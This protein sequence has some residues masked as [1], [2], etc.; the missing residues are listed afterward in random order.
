MSP[1]VRRSSSRTDNSRGLPAADQTSTEG[2]SVSRDAKPVAASSRETVV[3]V[4]GESGRAAAGPGSGAEPLHGSRSEPLSSLDTNAITR[5]GRERS[6]HHSQWVESIREPSH[7]YRSARAGKLRDKRLRK[8]GRL[9]LDGASDGEVADKTKWYRDRERAQRERID[10]VHAC[11][12]NLLQ[13]TCQSCERTH[14]R[15]QGCRYGLLCV[16]CR[17]LIAAEKRSRFLQ[18][19]VHWLEELNRAGLIGER[20]GGKRYSEKMLTLTVPHL[21]TDTVMRRIERVFAVWT[22]FLRKLNKFFRERRIKRAHYYRVFEWTLGEAD[23]IGNP[24][25]H[26]WLLC[27]FLDRDRLTLMLRDALNA[28]GCCVDHPVLD[29]RAVKDGQGGAYELI[30]YLTKDITA[31]GEKVPPN[32]YAQVLEAVETRRLTQPS[33][34]FLAPVKTHA[35]ACECGSELP[36]IVRT[37]PIDAS[38]KGSETR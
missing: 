12:A 21:S 31:S 29:I 28:V 4:R 23:E 22:Q 10:R 26:V 18:A 3:P 36:R 15:A 6:V 1:H 33:A 7:P 13:I 30:K 35:G 16:Y 38:G 9:R 17:G 2:L 20:A 19:R 37:K 11:G 14:E 24:H 34:G 8:G 27:P 32:I 25:L 5:P